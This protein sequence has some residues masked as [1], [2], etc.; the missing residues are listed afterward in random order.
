MESY[1][2]RTISARDNPSVWFKS[3]SCAIKHEESSVKYVIKYS[4][5]LNLSSYRQILNI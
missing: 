2:R 5:I 4:Y 3:E 1:F